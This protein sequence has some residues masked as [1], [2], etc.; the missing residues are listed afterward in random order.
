MA[1]R[2]GNN[3]NSE[4]LFLGSKTTADA[5]CSHEIKRCLLHGRKLMTNLD[6][7]L[8]SRDITLSTIVCLV[9]A[10]FFPVGMYRCES[11]AM[12]E[13]EHRRIDDFTLCCWK[14]LFRVPWTARRYSQSTLKEINHL[15]SWLE[16]K[17]VHLL[18]STIWSFLKKIKNRTTY[19]LTIQIL[20]LSKEMK[21]VYQRHICIPMFIAALLMSAN[22]W[23]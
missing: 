2:L 14:R 7:F 18:W 15:H 20:G 1:N 8:K 6:S 5:D 19:D 3:G 21:S 12:K 16:W 4:R 11:W 22:V 17:M 13:A 10:M 23:K 9:K